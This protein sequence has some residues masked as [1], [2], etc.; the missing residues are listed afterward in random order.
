MDVF[1][2]LGVGCWVLGAGC[3]VLGDGRPKT[4]DRRPRNLQIN[5]KPFIPF[6]YMAYLTARYFWVASLFYP[7]FVPIGIVFF[8]Q[9]PAKRVFSGIS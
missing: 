9:I 8:N 2:I 7:Y 4:E 5:Y 6:A 1:L 3:W